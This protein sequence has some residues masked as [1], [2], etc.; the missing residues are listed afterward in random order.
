MRLLK[1][2]YVTRHLV[3]FTPAEAL[4]LRQLGMLPP[5]GTLDELWW[6]ADEIRG[7][8]AQLREAAS[9][10]AITPRITSLDAMADAWQAILDGI[11]SAARERLTY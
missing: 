11:V 9:F 10:G 1:S 3:A 2:E 5:D 7:W 4:E 8:V 6:T